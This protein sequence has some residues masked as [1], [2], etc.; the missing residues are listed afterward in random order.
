LTSYV[1]ASLSRDHDRNGFRCGVEALDRYLREFAFQD[2]KRRV[3]GCFVMLDDADEIAGFYTLAATSVPLNL[4]PKAVTKKLPR[5]PVLPAMLIGRLAV[6][7]KRQGQG[8]G[9]ALI[10][11]AIIRTEGFRIGAYALIVDAK[12]ERACDFYA[13]NGFASIPD[14]AQRMF[15]PMAT[16]LQLFE[17]ERGG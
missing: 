15:L 4:L 8:L 16:A 10:A 14:E 9:R 12:D 13:A 5:Y 7:M 1:T 6:A 11:D 17:S 2:I 3:A